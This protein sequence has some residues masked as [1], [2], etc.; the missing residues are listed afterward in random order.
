MKYMVPHAGDRLMKKLWIK[1]DIWLGYHICRSKIPDSLNG[2]FSR[3]QTSAIRHFSVC[4]HNF[5]FTAKQHHYLGKTI[6]DAGNSQRNRS[7]H[8]HLHSTYTLLQVKT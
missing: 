7:W 5:Q 3:Q 4:S 2:C 1:W 6:V 8:S